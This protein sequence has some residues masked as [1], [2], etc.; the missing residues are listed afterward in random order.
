MADFDVDYDNVDDN[1]SECSIGSQGFES[2][3]DDESSSEPSQETV[4]EEDEENDDVMVGMEDEDKEKRALEQVRM[5]AEHDALKLEVLQIGSAK[6]ISSTGYGQFHEVSSCVAVLRLVQCG[7]IAV[8]QVRPGQNLH[9]AIIDLTAKNPHLLR[10][11]IVESTAENRTMRVPAHDL[12][13][14]KGR[15][16]ILDGVPRKSSVTPNSESLFRSFI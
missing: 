1:A 11:H 2:E 6:K 8:D 12:I 13:M 14:E 4:S 5:K 10:N 3:D 9:S 16:V 7:F 15:D